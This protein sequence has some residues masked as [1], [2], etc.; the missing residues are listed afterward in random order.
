[1]GNKEVYIIGLIPLARLSV[2][3]SSL[4]SLVV[5]RCC[6]DLLFKELFLAAVKANSS[7]CG[8]RTYVIGY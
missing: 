4:W 2:A 1:M 6:G 7:M 8:V 3:G 5:G